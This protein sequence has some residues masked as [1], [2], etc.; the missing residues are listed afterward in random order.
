[1]TQKRLSQS[2]G[3]GTNRSTGQNAGRLFIVSAPSGAGKTTLCEAVLDHFDDLI[4]SVSYTTRARRKGER[5]A[6]D[7]FFISREEFEQGI[8]QNRWAEWAK[9]HE[10]YYGTS[11]RRIARDLAKG[12]NILLDIDVQGMHKLLK[13]FPEA[14]TIFIAAPSMEELRRRLEQRATDDT[15]TVELRMANAESEMAQQDRYRHVVVND[16]LAKA[17]QQLISILKRYMPS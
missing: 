3:A 7:Y 15:R 6:V 12:A 11:A 14:V 8:G 2:S 13:Q 1:M 4:Y 5:H 9:V 17:R 16:D 10:N